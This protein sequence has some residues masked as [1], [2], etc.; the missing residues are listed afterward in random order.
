MR[1]AASTATL[2]IIVVV[3]VVVAGGAA[4]FVFAGKGGAT[5]S[6]PGTSSGQVSTSAAETALNG[7]VAAFNK[8]NITGIVSFYSP[9]AIVVWT[10]NPKAL[11][12]ASQA[13]TYSGTGNIKLLYSTTIANSRSISVTVS[14]LQATSTSSSV[15]LNF[16]LSMQGDSSI[17]GP[18]N[19]TITASQTWVQSG[20][21]YQITNEKWY[22]ATFNTQNQVTAT[23]FPQWGLSLQGKNPDLASEHVAEWQVA[24][25]L[26]AV[27]Y[28]SL[29]VIVAYVV[30]VRPRKPER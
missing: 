8:A 11:A 12:A 18:F 25:Y 6:T 23:V 30:W 16:T 19:G 5:S 10:A 9:N 3:I 2:A 22:Y 14:G 28:A 13:G 20:N 4:Y 17:L 1:R 26:A 15:I 21:N 24:P 7:Y 29:I 27:L